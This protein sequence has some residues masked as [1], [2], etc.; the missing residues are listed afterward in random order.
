MSKRDWLE[1]PREPSILHLVAIHRIVA[2][3]DGSDPTPPMDE[4]A[5]RKLPRRIVAIFLSYWLKEQGYSIP[6]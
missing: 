6:E 5:L 1:V 4:S 3:I 2:S